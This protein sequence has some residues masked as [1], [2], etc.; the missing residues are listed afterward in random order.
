M[1]ES[2]RLRESGTETATAGQRRQV[3]VLFAD[4]VGYMP[5]AEKLG[6]E[7]TYLFMQRIHRE[8]SEAVHAQKG[9]VQEITGDGVMALFGAPVALEDAPLRACHAALDIISRMTNIG[10]EIEAKYGARPAFRVGLHS[11][12]LIIG[13]V[14]DAQKMELT[15]LGDTVNFASRLESF[16]DNGTIAI[17]EA[18][19]ALVADYTDCEFIGEHEIKGRSEVQKLWRLKAVK[20]GI[21]RFDTSRAHGLTPLVGRQQDLETL[22]QLWREARDGQIRLVSIG[23]EAGIG[24]SR[25]LHEFR[26]HLDDSAFVLE[27][28]CAA[29]GQTVPFLP[30]ADVVRRSFGFSSNADQK[31]ARRRLQRG[32]EFLGLDAEMHLS[33]LL[34]LLGYDDGGGARANV[35]DEARGIRTRDA[36]IAILNERCQL[37]PTI[38]II[39]D[40]HW[41]DRASESLLSR[42]QGS[43]ETLPLLIITTHR[44]GYQPPWSGQKSTSEILLKPLSSAG[45]ADLLKTRLDVTEL[46]DDLTRLVS[47]KA[48]G[49]PLF[50]EEITNYLL[51]SGSLKELDDGLSFSVSA[52]ET[53]LPARLENMLM[54]RIDRLEQAPRRVLEAAAVLG[55]RFEPDLLA[56]MTGLGDDLAT[57]L[58]TLEAQELVFCEQGRDAYRF[59]HALVQDVVYAGML[60]SQRRE[61]HEVAGKAVETI[62]GP[63]AAD[64]LAHHFSRTQRTEKAIQYLALA[65]ENSLRI[66]SLEE[67][68]ERFEAALALVEDHPNAVSDSLLTDILLHIARTKYFQLEF[69]AIID[70]VQKYLPRVEALGDKKRLSRFL[71]EGG[72]A[73]VFAS[74]AKTGRKLLE[75][76]RAIG[77]ETGDELA[78]AYADL[79]SMWDRV[80]WGEPGE[81]RHEAQREAG[82]RIMAVGRRHNDIWLA[83]KGGLALGMDLMYWGQPAEGRKV[84]MQLMTMSQES[85]DPRPRTMALWALAGADVVSGNYVEA[86][87]NADEALRVCISP[88]DIEISKGFKA[89]AMIMNGQTEAGREIGRAILEWESK[90]MLHTIESFKMVMGVGLFMLGDMA[91]GINEIEA[92][93]LQAESSGQTMFIPFG[94]FCIGQVYLQMAISEDRPPL[95]VMLRNF[96]FL[97]RTLP[98]VKQKARHYL[99]SALEKYR[100]QDNT[101]AIARCLYSIGSLD[102]AE[103]HFDEAKINFQE[104]HDLAQL[105]GSK[106]IVTDAKAK[107]ADLPVN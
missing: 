4:M 65:G 58:V 104:A 16:A 26:S 30:F 35:A 5:I 49:N 66:Y 15:A 45:I 57:Q 8:L 96:V 59:K 69:F 100:I 48:Q 107:L 12:P 50:A 73:N 75:Q 20:Q 43:S 61:L 60:S 33:Y 9:T 32:L 84:L 70:L 89:T 88:F 51:Q 80:Y 1:A 29:D 53:V 39:E 22:E 11:G 79:G 67:A 62:K 38:M 34:N 24:K 90:G 40:L 55:Q 85:N 52:Q 46:P 92:A 42:I 56:H 27:G 102:L 71:F 13:A 72:Y 83:S 81:T 3:T 93:T 99:Q 101:S 18:T 98:F 47:E 17:S 63:E 7:D 76:A 64:A 23:G 41:M 74:K 31:E 2:P 95:S 77:E 87:E 54:E 36:V 106:N 21:S 14:G 78:I 10:G 82:E 25:L 37:T 68:V 105:A 97:L 44:P 103:N 91:L 86:I 28:Y 94:D 19:H 6:E